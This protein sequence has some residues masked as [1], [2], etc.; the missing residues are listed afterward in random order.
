MA[1]FPKGD[2]VLAQGDPFAMIDVPS[3]DKI[4]IRDREG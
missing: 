4:A 1:I 3:I 2:V